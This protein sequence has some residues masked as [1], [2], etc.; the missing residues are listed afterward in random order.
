MSTLNEIMDTL[1][2]IDRSIDK[3]TPI[4]KST[5][6]LIKESNGVVKFYE[7]KPNVKS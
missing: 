5:K 6:R 1:K 3:L 2:R 4:I 7:G